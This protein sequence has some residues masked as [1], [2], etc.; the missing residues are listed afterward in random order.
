MNKLVELINK[1]IALTNSNTT[2]SLA[3][4]LAKFKK[5]LDNN[6]ITQEEYETKKKQLLNL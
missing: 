6:A 2:V 1:K 3:D 5:L 4:E